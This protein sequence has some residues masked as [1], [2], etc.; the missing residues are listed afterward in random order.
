MVGC[1]LDTD[2]VNHAALVFYGGQGLGKTTWLNN[3][4]PKELNDYKHN[5]W[6]NPKNKD[7]FVALAEKMLINIDELEA[8]RANEIGAF[9]AMVTLPSINIRRVYGHSTEHMPRRSSFA[10]STNDKGILTDVTGS[11]RFLVFETI[12]I[13]YQHNIPME[14]VYSQ[15]LQL[16]K[17]GFKFHFDKD[18]IEELNIANEQFKAIDTEEEWV[19]ELFKIAD[20]LDEADFVGRASDVTQYIAKENNIKSSVAMINRIGKILTRKG[21]KTFKRK[22]RKVYALKLVKNQ[23]EVI[24]TDELIHITEA[25]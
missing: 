25:G 17:T 7:T 15:A 16:Y 4:V 8:L 22:S 23:E 1:M 11:R 12:G 10:A 5:G 20:D 19:D 14:C 9:K 18:D 3:L 2:V 13:N 6:V 21:Y 24:T